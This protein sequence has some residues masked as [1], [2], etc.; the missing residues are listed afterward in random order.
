LSGLPSP[1]EA[2]YVKA[3]AFMHPNFLSKTES[4]VD[5]VFTFYR[6]FPSEKD[7]VKNQER[8]LPSC[9]CAYLF[10]TVR[11]PALLFMRSVSSTLTACVLL[12][13]PN[14]LLKTESGVVSLLLEATPCL[15]KI[16]GQ[17][18]NV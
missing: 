16:S 9:R 11:A 12:P 3:G 10:C 14:F 15:R 4:G 13:P 7:T 5:L 17:V 18:Q 2:G 8:L 6:L 1:A